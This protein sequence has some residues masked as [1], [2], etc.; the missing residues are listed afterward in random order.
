[1]MIGILG[2][3]RFRQ[4][5]NC[6]PSKAHD[7]VRMPLRIVPSLNNSNKVS[8]PHSLNSNFAFLCD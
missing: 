3:S 6:H 1:M 5:T 7:M 2:G 4:N 8:V